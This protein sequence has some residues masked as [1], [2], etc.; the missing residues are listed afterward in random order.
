MSM[1]QSFAA[2]TTP[3]QGPLR[4]SALRKGLAQAG[5]A[6]FLVP[7]ADAHQ[8]EYVARR[9]ERLAW[10]TGFT[11][12]AGF[13]AVLADQAG[14]FVDGR[15]RVQVRDQVADVFTPV[16]WPE[17]RL[18]DWLIGALPKGGV[19]GFDPWLHT[20]S[21]I[22]RM[23]K[24][25]TPAQ[26]S[27]RPVANMV[28]A[29]WEDQPTPPAA[30]AYAYPAE[31]AGKKS[32]EKRSEIARILQE[33]GQSAAVLTLPDSIAWLLNIRGGDLPHLPVTQAFGILHADARVSLFS[34]PAK[35][36]ALG[37]DPNID[38][39]PWD[40][41]EPV[42]QA[43]TGPVRVDPATAPHQVRLVLNAAGVAIAKGDDPCI[44]PKACKTEAE[45]AAT[46]TA[47]IR[48][49]LAMARFLHWFD[50]TA[51]GGGLTEIDCA[52][53]LEDFRA[54]TG[55]LRDISFDTISAAGPHAALPHY[56][57]STASNAPILPGQ[58][59]LVDSGGQYQDGTTDI[60]RTLAVGDVG[61]E[62][63][64]AFTQVLQGV[65][66]IHRLRFPKGLAGQHLDAFARAPL[67]AAGRDFDHGTGHGVGV[68]LSVHE[69]PQRLS[70]VSDVALLPGM[71][72]SN[73]PGYYREGGFGIRIENLIAVRPAPALPGGDDRPMLEFE[74]LTWA[75][76][77]RH[78]IAVAALNPVE[79]A[80]IDAYHA[81]VAAKIGP[82]LP[83]DTA[84]W[85]RQ[86]TA[87]L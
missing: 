54:E 23:E 14:V 26:I 18:E 45:I 71:I 53:K 56:R 52:R 57:V 63:R 75:P 22:T 19:V 12:S 20:S 41:F 27:L 70:R 38:L 35:F 29:I 25:L 68:F 47:H 31:I 77:D 1:F 13:C 84:I 3:E 67:W 17:T 60:T 39:H 81:Q 82:E 59:Y 33:A 87:P 48:D 5:L 61:A 40:E 9:D 73:E 62:V 80:W 72:L 83:L 65:I 28:D 32:G 6:G 30:P 79:R 43:L 49:G 85:L 44:L 8:G 46:R 42:L 58:V 2:T 16:N 7:R 66:A 11:G 36:A 10:L 86:A 15:Y 37:P 21:E 69:G 4:L 51:P 74:N 78:L 55:A 24:T 76:I 34:D 50:E 64:A